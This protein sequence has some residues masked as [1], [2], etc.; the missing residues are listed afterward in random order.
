[1]TEHPSMDDMRRERLTGP[2]FDAREYQAG[3]AEAILAIELAEAIRER[4]IELGLTQTQLAERAGL[5][6]PEVSR[7]ESGG[8][9][10][11][12]GMLERLAHALEVRFVARF[13]KVDAA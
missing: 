6:Q 5:R 13:E 7:L 10:P 2:G 4:R 12:I 8:G 1:M 11:T 3:R 9:T